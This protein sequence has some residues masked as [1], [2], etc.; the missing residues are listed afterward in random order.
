MNT[1]LPLDPTM[2]ADAGGALGVGAAAAV[3]SH[4]FPEVNS[5]W[6]K[7]EMECGG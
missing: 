7:T 6:D 1:A 5:A 3:R 2:L 4:L